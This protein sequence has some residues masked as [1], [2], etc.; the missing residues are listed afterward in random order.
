MPP[1]VYMQKNSGSVRLNNNPDKHTALQLAASSVTLQGRSPKKSWV[2]AF[3][4]TP[5]V[6]ASPKIH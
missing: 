5:Y 2:L 3:S 6:A 1:P 4:K